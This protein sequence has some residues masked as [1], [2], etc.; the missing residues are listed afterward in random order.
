MKKILH[1]I[2]VGWR[3]D[4]KRLTVRFT[5]ARW[6]FGVGIA[7]GYSTLRVG[8]IQVFFNYYDWALRFF[9]GA[10]G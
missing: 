8:P 5:P 7:L 4:W 10:D 9:G 6:Y 3:V 1:S 2:L